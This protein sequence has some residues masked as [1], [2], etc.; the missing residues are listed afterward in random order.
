MIALCAGVVAFGGTA[1]AASSLPGSGAAL[2]TGGL[3]SSSCTTRPVTIGYTT[4]FTPGAGYTVGVV[5]LTGLDFA[6]C[7]GKTAQVTLSDASGAPLAQG[8]ASLRNAGL[9][10][11]GV[12]TVPLSG[13]A[14]V[15]GIA[16]SDLV[17]G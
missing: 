10:A 9:V 12:L 11:G 14:P 7:A 1:V 4:A 5:T 2:A 13:V 16:R 17:L 6:A 3:P 8:S 15:G